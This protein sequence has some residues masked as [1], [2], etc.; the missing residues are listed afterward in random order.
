MLPIS[1]DDASWWEKTANERLTWLET[2]PN[3][4]TLQAGKQ[5]VHSAEIWSL[6]PMFEKLAPE[7][8]PNL[9]KCKNIVN[10]ATFNV[11]ILKTTNQLNELTASA[12]EHNIDIICVQEFSY[13]QSELDLKY[14]EPVM[15]GHQSR[16]LHGRTLS[17][18]T[19]K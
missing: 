19:L 3:Y 9:L 12:S 15:D 14:H 7:P 17:L 13:Y 5:E 6:A 10:I 8:K 16:Y 18:P 11:T 1:N 4:I 2:K